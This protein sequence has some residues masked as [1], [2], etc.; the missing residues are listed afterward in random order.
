VEME[1]H[2]DVAKRAAHDTTTGAEKHHPSQAPKRRRA[3][4]YVGADSIRI[5]AVQASIA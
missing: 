1:R 2:V 5:A 4:R 3:E